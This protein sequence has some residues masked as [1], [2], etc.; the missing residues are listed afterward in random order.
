MQSVTLLVD[1]TERV[2]EA[3]GVL[4]D[5]CLEHG[6]TIP[7]L[8]HVKGM[9]EP[10]ASCRLCFVE[11]E[12]MER[13]VCSCTVRVTE[14]MHVRTDTPAVREL[15]RAALQMLLSA[16]EVDCGACPAN[17]RCELQ[18]IAK[19]LKVGLRPRHL[20]PLRKEAGFASEHPF[21][22][23]HPNRCVLCGRCVYVCRAKHGRPYLTFAQRGFETVVSFH[24][25]KG[26]AAL[27]C[28]DRIACVEACPVAAI[29]LREGVGGPERGLAEPSRGLGPGAEEGMTGGDGKRP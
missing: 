10:A 1:G 28:T 2:V 8:C 27:A 26:L 4:L 11:I 7:N 29:T 24:G 23:Y 22:A 15:Q 3:G 18:K 25:E 5:V 9:E 14:G 21:L 20:P 13:P 12:G 17:K 19:F 6:I 16:H